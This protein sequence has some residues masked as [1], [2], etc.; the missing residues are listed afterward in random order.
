MELQPRQFY[1]NFVVPVTFD[2]DYCEEIASDCILLNS[3]PFTGYSS[4]RRPPLASQPVRSMMHIS[5]QST[6]SLP[7]MYRKLR[8]DAKGGLHL[9]TKVSSSR[10]FRLDESVFGDLGSLRRLHR[11]LGN[12][13]T[14]YI[15]CCQ[16]RGIFRMK[17]LTFGSD[18]T[19]APTTKSGTTIQ[20]SRF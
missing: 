18:S 20:L 4:L 14:N 12:R 9:E 8:L 1:S 16:Y 13:F 5:Q 19:L 7:A 6:R 10:G 11:V 17:A 15:I 3:Y 2:T